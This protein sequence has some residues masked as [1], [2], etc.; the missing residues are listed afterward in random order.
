M[1]VNYLMFI[2]NICDFYSSVIP[3]E[4]C[5]LVMYVYAKPKRANS[6]RSD[7]KHHASFYRL[8]SSQPGPVDAIIP[9]NG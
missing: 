6:Y 8:P 4:L 9:A 1:F 7:T 5:Y 2:L 3:R